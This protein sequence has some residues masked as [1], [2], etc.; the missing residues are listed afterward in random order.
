MNAKNAVGG[1]GAATVPG[2]LVVGVALVAGSMAGLRAQRDHYRAEAASPRPTATVT[3]PGA[4]PAPG[5]TSAV[6]HPGPSS[7]PAATVVAVS[8]KQARLPHTGDGSLSHAQARPPS[9]PQPTPTP[10]GAAPCSGGVSVRL[11]LGVLPRCALT[12]GGSR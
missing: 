12:V 1:L 3:A 8:E 5:S 2:A 9:A 10:T 6:T 4:R 11:P 7:T